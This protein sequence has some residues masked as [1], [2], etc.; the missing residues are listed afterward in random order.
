MDIPS[1]SYLDLH[2]FASK[3]QRKLIV[4]EPFEF[5][6]PEELINNFNDDI[7]KKNTLNIKELNNDCLSCLRN[8]ANLYTIY[9]RNFI[10]DKWLPVYVGESKSEGMRERITQHLIY[11]H[12]ETGSKLNNV[13]KIVRNGGKIGLSLLK[14]EPESLRLYVEEYIINN[15]GQDKLVW[16]KHGR[17]L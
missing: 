17:I 6:Y 15:S 10:S 4:D 1:V 2:D 5:L 14:V 3:C 11:K 16:N 8:N 7:W 9:T 12:S 13:K